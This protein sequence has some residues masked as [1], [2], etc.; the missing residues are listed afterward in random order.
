VTTNT[1]G[2][3]DDKPATLFFIRDVDEDRSYKEKL[4]DLA[5][6][7]YLTGVPNRQKLKEDFDGIS[8]DIAKGDLCG[9]MA[10]ID[11]DN[12][13][14]INDSYGHNTGDVMLRRLTEHLTSDPVFGGHIYRL[15]GDEFVLLYHD[16][17][18]RF[19][20]E[21]ELKAYYADMLK[22]AFLSYTMPN[23][24]K[25]STISMGVAIFPRH[26]D[27]YSEI[28]RKADI[29]LYKA[30]KNG[31]NQLVFLRTNTTPPKNLKTCT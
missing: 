29:A 22:G 12:F 3:I 10:L 25:E 27:S 20:S 24:E 7:D 8:E 6:M 14:D 11:M 16:R 9:I 15:G 21:D 5:Y 1:V 30:K 18:D 19:Q 17:A 28:L 4:Y 31:R 26:G 23:I 2:W 13:K